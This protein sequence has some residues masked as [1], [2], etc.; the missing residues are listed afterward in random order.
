MSRSFK[1]S[2]QPGSPENGTFIHSMPKQNFNGLY[3]YLALKQCAPSNC[4]SLQNKTQ[5]IFKFCHWI[6]KENI[7]F[8]L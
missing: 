8:T 6:G 7:F 2:L 5:R 1:G 4:T 3:I